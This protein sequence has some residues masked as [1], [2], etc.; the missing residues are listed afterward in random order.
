MPEAHNEADEIE[1]RAD[2]VQEILTAIPHWII[3]WGMT[4]VFL[5]V[6]MVITA[7]FFIKYPDTIDSRIVLTTEV[8][9]TRV[10]ALSSGKVDFFVKD[11]QMVDE[12]FLLG[13][14]ENPAETEDV[15][16]LENQLKPLVEELKRGSVSTE[17]KDWEEDWQLGPL[18]P[19]FLL[20]RNALLNFERYEELDF[21]SQQIAALESR[22]RSYNQLNAELDNQN[23]IYRQELEITSEQFA[24]DSTL[25]LKKSL[26]Q[27]EYAS[28]RNQL[29]QTRRA[30]QASKNQV[31]NNNITIDQLRAQIGELRLNQRK[32]EDELRSA[33]E[34]N[35]RSLESQVEGWKQQYLLQAPIGGQITF[36]AIWSDNQ[37]VAASTEVLTIVPDTATMLD[38]ELVGQVLAPVLN[39]GKLK[40][41]QRVNIRFDNYPA[42]EYGMVLGEVIN[43]SSVPTADSYNVQVR[44]TQ[45]LRTTYK[46][47][48][49]YRPEM[50]GS[51]QIITEDLRLIE[52]IFNQFRALMDRAS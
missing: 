13:V 37:F 6:V 14:I 39:S 30:Y 42:N 20:L 48:L 51:A 4:V 34:E 7:S 8:P 40:I 49:A 38:E 26:T 11:K 28:S 21:Y 29:L 1:I 15:I 24:I 12:N 25:Y 9:P 45:G 50:S 17:L 32:E 33:I 3:R 23:N 31:I 52:R 47:N 5:S 43:I 19:A 22:I 10:V 41:G 46:K 44:L 2:E 36:S 16:S 27:R 18:Q 35:L